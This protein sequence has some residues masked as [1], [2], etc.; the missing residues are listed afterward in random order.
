MSTENERLARE[1]RARAGQVGGHPLTLD[2]IKGSA[3]SIRR[4]QRLVTGGVAAAVL[5]VAVPFGFAVTDRGTSDGTP[6][7]IAGTPTGPVF[8]TVTFDELVEGAVSDVPYLVDGQ[9]HT[10]GVVTEVGDASD[11]TRYR[12]GFVVAVNDDDTGLKTLSFRDADGVEYDTVVAR[13]TPVAGA[14]GT[15][16][17]FVDAE[18]TLVVTPGSDGGPVPLRTDGADGAIEPVAVLGSGACVD[19]EVE[20]GSACA[21]FFSDGLGTE[22]AGPR[23]VD[24][25]GTLDTAGDYLSLN[26][27]SP[28]G[29]VTVGMTSYDEMEPSSCSAAR[30]ADGATLWE[31]CAYTPTDFSPDGSL[32]LGLPSY[33]D[34]IGNGV[35]SIL[36]ADTGELV[37]E[38]DLGSE[39]FIVDAVWESTETLVAA[40]FS[41]DAQAWALLR[42]STDGSYEQIP[43]VDLG[44]ED[45]SGPRLVR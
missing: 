18:G 38:F 23:V 16:L 30:G 36:D 1:L 31:T 21:V 12:D 41:Y 17:T 19:P 6:P 15:V 4:R 25:H 40:A 13:T 34:G 26:G 22:G 7:P 27:V 3:T 35:N 5:A 28:D 14:D 45:V 39:G 24:T 29:D 42:L 9:V 37:A 32:V 33:L 44:S 2:D 43:S 10:A 20:A 11:V 8:T